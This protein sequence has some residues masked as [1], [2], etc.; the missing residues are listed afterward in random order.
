MNIPK[1]PYMLLSFINTKLRDD[2]DSLE[3]FCESYNV[4]IK[5]IE[6]IYWE[7]NYI[8]KLIWRKDANL[9][10]DEAFFCFQSKFINSF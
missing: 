7:I 5:E 2:F 1:D 9:I 4:N 3:N 10:I 6:E 8:K